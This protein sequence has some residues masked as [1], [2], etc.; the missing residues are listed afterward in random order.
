MLLSFRQPFFPS[1]VWYFYSFHDVI[2]LFSAYR[3]P[4]VTLS[5]LHSESA[6]ADLIWVIFKERF[7][8]LP[9]EQ[10]TVARRR[11]RDRLSLEYV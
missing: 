4:L 6:F 7:G 10:R 9:L 1:L 11:A 8:P 2:G 5:S 3:R